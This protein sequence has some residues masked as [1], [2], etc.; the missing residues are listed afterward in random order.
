MEHRENKLY[1][2]VV[3]SPTSYNG[4]APVK[5]SGDVSKGQNKSFVRNFYSCELFKN[6]DLKFHPEKTRTYVIKVMAYIER[7]KK[8]YESPIGLR[9]P[10]GPSTLAQKIKEPPNVNSDLIKI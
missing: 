6:A 4:K 2:A 9:G 5:R 3:I 1:T 7:Q 8:D 10:S